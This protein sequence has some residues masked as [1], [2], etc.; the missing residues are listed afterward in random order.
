MKHRATTYRWGA[1][2]RS[3]IAGLVPFKRRVASGK[4]NCEQVAGLAE[5]RVRVVGDNRGSGDVY[6]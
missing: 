3:N 6:Q 5:H 1:K 4:E 2:K